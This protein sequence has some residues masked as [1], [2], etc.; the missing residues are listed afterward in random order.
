[1]FSISNTNCKCKVLTGDVYRT[2]SLPGSDYT[3]FFQDDNYVRLHVSFSYRIETEPNY[4]FHEGV[5][6]SV[7]VHV[8]DVKLGKKKV[9]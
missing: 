4:C 5:K 6:G 3:T 2:S 1:M 8:D 9:K 7:T